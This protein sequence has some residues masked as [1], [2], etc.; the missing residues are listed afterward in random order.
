MYTAITHMTFI[1][2]GLLFA[3]ISR[4]VVH[5]KKHQTTVLTTLS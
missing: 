1:L 3:I 5:T 2:S 4:V